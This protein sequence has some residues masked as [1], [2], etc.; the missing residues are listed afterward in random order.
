MVWVNALFVANPRVAL[1][2]GFRGMIYPGS[3]RRSDLN[4]NM[5]VDDDLTLHDLTPVQQH[6]KA[7]FDVHRAAI[8][9]NAESFSTNENVPYPGLIID[10]HTEDETDSNRE[11]VP[12]YVR[13]DPT[14]DDELL[15]FMIYCAEVM[16]LPW[17]M[18]YQTE[19]YKR[20]RL[21]GSLSGA[22]VNHKNQKKRYPSLT[23]ELGPQGRVDD[24]F[25]KFGVA[26]IRNLMVHFGMLDSSDPNYIGDWYH[27]PDRQLKE[28]E[29]IFQDRKGPLRLKDAHWVDA[30]GVHFESHHRLHLSINPGDYVVS[31]A[32][33]GKSIGYLQPLDYLYPE[34]NIA[35]FS[36]V[37]GFVLSSGGKEIFRPE[38]GGLA[39]LAAVEEDD[40]RIN[41]IYQ[42]QLHKLWKL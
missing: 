38:K 14:E 13:I 32:N 16:G 26:A 41:R 37:N 21:N 42:E 11:D 20:E 17:V 2:E 19:E 30:N 35:V 27:H 6:A 40:P 39:F 12:P 28:F 31:Q 34:D 10:F 22:L 36:D 8:D 24:Y 15:G 4:R 18:D 23:I 33:G 7:V 9:D 25:T 3:T 5:S 1:R 29:D